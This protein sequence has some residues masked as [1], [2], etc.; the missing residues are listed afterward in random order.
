M[1]KKFHFYLTLFSLVLVIATLSYGVYAAIQSQYKVTSQMSFTPVDVLVEVTGIKVYQADLVDNVVTKQTNPI[2][3]IASGFY[4]STFNPTSENITAPTVNLD[5][6]SFNDETNKVVRRYLVFEIY[7]KNYSENIV[8]ASLNA[9]NAVQNPS[10]LPTNVV[11][12]SNAGEDVTTFSTTLASA[13]GVTT[14]SETTAPTSTANASN[15]ALVIIL[16]LDD[17]EQR[18]DSQDLSLNVMFTKSV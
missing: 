18:I 9:T 11:L 8:S 3:N 2:K 6:I 15:Q 17:L 12:K 16:Y 1:R 10:V 13:T 4:T 5:K 14:P 7:Y